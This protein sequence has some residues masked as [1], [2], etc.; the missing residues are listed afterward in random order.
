MDERGCGCGCVAWPEGGASGNGAVT[1]ADREDMEE[2]EEE[3]DEEEE[4]DENEG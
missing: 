3:E 2:E 4:D 1:G